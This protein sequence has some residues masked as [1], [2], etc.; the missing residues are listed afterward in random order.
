MSE[1]TNENEV[2]VLAIQMERGLR[3]RI[4]NAAVREHRT[5][6]SFARFYLEKAADES[7]AAEAAKLQPEEV[8]P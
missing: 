4:K 8:Q 1:T 7:D 6:S 3:Q 2:T 5:E